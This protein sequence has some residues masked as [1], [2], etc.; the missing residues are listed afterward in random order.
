M[1]IKAGDD[2]TTDQAGF[3]RGAVSWLNRFEG[4]AA[5]GVL[6]S[7]NPRVRASDRGRAVTWCVGRFLDEHGQY[8]AS[9][10]ENYQTNPHPGHACK[11]ETAAARALRGGGPGEVSLWWHGGIWLCTE[12]SRMTDINHTPERAGWL[13]VSVPEK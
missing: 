1:I 11:T 7:I 2:I 12:Q 10:K 8:A 5:F 9:D 4:Y 3:V 13:R 6:E